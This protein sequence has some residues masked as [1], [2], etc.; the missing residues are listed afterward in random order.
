MDC[1]S[2]GKWWSGSCS[3]GNDRIQY[4]LK[5][6]RFQTSHMLV[7]CEHCV[8]SG[9]TTGN[10]ATFATRQKLHPRDLTGFPVSLHVF[11]LR[12]VPI[13]RS[14]AQHT[15]LQAGIGFCLCGGPLLWWA[16]VIYQIRDTSYSALD[17]WQQP[18]NQLLNNP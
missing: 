14:G 6:T 15:H 10:Q 9:L 16:M 3:T 1:I 5:K 18:L 4:R 13:I 17:A 12:R 2:K 11:L 7:Y 8:H